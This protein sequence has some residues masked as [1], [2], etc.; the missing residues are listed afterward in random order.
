MPG[1]RLNHPIDQTYEASVLIHTS[2][3]SSLDEYYFAQWHNGVAPL[4]PPVFR[5]IT[6]V[7]PEFQPLRNAVLAISAAY[8]AHSESL[9][10][11]NAHRN[12]Y[13]PQKDHQYQSLQYY[14]KVI[15]GISK[16]VEMLPHINSL[17]VLAALLL[18][19]YFELDSGSFTGGI[20]HMTVIDKFLSSHHN[21]IKSHPT[22]PKLLS[23]WMNLRSQFVNRYL[24]S[25]TSSAPTLSI[26]TF[27]LNRKIDHG[28]SHRDSITIMLCDAK[29]LSRRIIL[30]WCVARGESRD[31]N[32]NSPFGNILTQISLPKT[33]TES[34]S[35]LAAIDNSY[36]ESLAKQ[37]A[38]LDDW[39]STLDLS[40]LPIE[41]YVS[42]RQDSMKHSITESDMLEI[43]PL[44]F[45]SF[46]AAMN[47]ANYAHAHMMCSQDAIDRLLNPEFVV[48]PLTRKDCPWPELI[49]R[50]TAGL[51]LADCVY[52][53]TFNA[54]ILSILTTCIVLCPRADV[55]AWIQEWIRKVEDLGVP[56]ENGLPFGIIKRIIRF[57]LT[58]REDGNDVLLI[59]PL[60]TEQA[61]K[62]DLYHSD[63]KMKAAVCGKRIYTGKLYSEITEVPEE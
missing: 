37:R 28:V 20:G 2:N 19:Y 47:Y 26:D 60:D 36:Q 15:Q 58:Q 1:S 25:Y 41:S 7:M 3:P 61:E 14:N 21:V 55:A 49:L 8:V 22:G 31:T 27:P 10:V 43:R 45:Q 50:I 63:Y 59:V 13:L 24:G 5:E 54:G 6:T 39:H 53:N 33:R 29:L 30:D 35:E 52:K 23:T 11:R 4:L 34:A 16:S 48:P 56:L 32:E 46:D 44:K 40:E 17:H 18:S 57:V 62:S 51:Q 9:V 38:T 12:R 42:Q